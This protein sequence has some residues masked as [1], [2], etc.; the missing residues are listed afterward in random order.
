M[1]KLLLGKEVNASINEEIKAKVEKLKAQDI[2][3]ALGIIRIG[4]RE[5]DIAYEKSAAK[6]CETLGVAYEKFLL[7]ADVKEEEVLKTISQVN[8]NDKI[9]GVLLFRGQDCQGAGGRKRCRWNYGS[10]Y[11]RSFHGKRYGIRTMY[12]KCLHEGAGALRNRLHG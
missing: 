3:P 4:E 8:K 7:P 2:T 10:F 5:D 1:A 11:G 9:H 12:A 6:R